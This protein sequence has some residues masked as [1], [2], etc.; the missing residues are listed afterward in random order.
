MRL[1]IRFHKAM[2]KMKY[3]TT[4]IC[5]SVIAL[6][7]A[8]NACAAHA[9]LFGPSVEKLTPIE[10]KQLL[11]TSVLSV[12]VGAQ[13]APLQTNTKAGAVGGFI[14]GSIVSSVVGSAAM[15]SGMQPGQSMQ[16]MQ[17]LQQTS[18]EIGQQAGQLTGRMAT[19]AANAQATASAAAMATAG[20]GA[21][22]L[23][24]LVDTLRKKLPAGAVVSASDSAGNSAPN[25]ALRVNQMQWLLDFRV[26]SSLYDLKYRVQTVV[27]NK[28]SG[29]LIVEHVCDGTVDESHELDQ[30]KADDNK[31]IGDA[32][33][34]IA[35]KCAAEFVAQLGLDDDTS[36]SGVTHET[37][38][39]VK[40]SG[41]S[42]Q[43]A[44]SPS[45][46]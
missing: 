5:H 38:D 7:L 34:H 37:D 15:S 8:A 3:R 12:P 35:G 41:G 42:E 40:R 29:K 10:R 43:A 11:A 45:A 23:P 36:N 1:A 13:G 6:A 2:I 32:A 9:G 28:Q 21:A 14:L 31:L 46:K 44:Q 30:W 39:G 24:L 4:G 27:E 20:P 26:T 25:L 18:M 17:Q 33:Q 16:Q 19:N 22:M